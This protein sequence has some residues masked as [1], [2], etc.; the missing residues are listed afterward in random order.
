MFYI[1]SFHVLRKNCLLTH[2]LESNILG[3]TERMGRRR[4]R[5][6]KLL[7]NLRTY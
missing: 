6:K 7:D 2:G 5:R 1:K 4:R 3:K